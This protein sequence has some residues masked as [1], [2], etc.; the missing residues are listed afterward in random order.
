MLGFFVYLRLEILIAFV[1]IDTLP[2]HNMAGHSKWHNIQVRK[3]K[4]DKL[5]ANLFTKLARA[6]TVAAQS[7]GADVDINFALRLAIEKA[8]AAN[9]PKDNI[10]RAIKK[11]TGELKDGAAIEEIVY[12]GFGPGGVAFVVEAMTDNKNRTSSDMKHAF[13]KYGGSMGG[14]GSVQWQFEYKGVVRFTAEKKKHIVEWDVF[15]LALIDAGAEDIRDSENGVEAIGPIDRLRELLQVL[16]KNNIEP[17]DSGLEWIPKETISIDEE[18]SGKIDI[19][20]DA[21]DELDDVKA[22]YTNVA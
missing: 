16:E 10:D 17:D 22:V 18:T 19:L 7:G 5:R 6:I 3:G 4:Q 11:G 13:S 9:M 12:E 14:P 8:R 21:L 1:S 15:E 2:T 20:Y